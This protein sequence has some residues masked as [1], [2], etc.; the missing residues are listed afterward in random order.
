MSKYSVTDDSGNTWEIVSGSNAFN[1]IKR[2][3]FS[4]VYISLSVPFFNHLLDNG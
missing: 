1:I 3:L 2:A 4:Y